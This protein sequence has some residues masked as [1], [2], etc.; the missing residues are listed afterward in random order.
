MPSPLTFLLCAA[1][2][3][4]LGAAPVARALDPAT[5][6][7]DYHHT[8]WTS[9]DGAPAEITSMAQ[10]QDGWLWL[11]TPTGV[12]RFDGV[13]FEPYQ[14]PAGSRLLH[15]RISE[16][17]AMPNGD[18]W[19]GYVGRGLSLRHA[20][21][22]LEHVA[23]ADSKVRDVFTLTRDR[24]GSIWAA[25][26]LGTRRYDAQRRWQAIGREAG[27]PAASLTTLADQHGRLY[28][29]ADDGTYVLDRASAKFERISTDYTVSLVESPD[30]QLWGGG[31]GV[32]RKLPTPSP[33]I[34]RPDWLNQ[35]EGH[36]AGI[37]DRD[38]NLWT[39]RCPRGLCLVRQPQRLG[40]RI[41]PARDAS[42]KFDQ[43]WQLSNLS[44]NLLL[45]DRLGNI[46]LSTQAG[47]E[48]FRNAAVLAAPV[49]GA[50][51]FYRLAR[52]AGDTVWVTDVR[53]AQVWR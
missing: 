30:G 1:G 18:L 38:G 17:V 26:T 43:P 14:P 41:Q 42:E 44:T 36:A 6:L 12:Y 19:I 34:A 5:A 51:G 13:R 33:T 25:S 21:G 53:A 47:L 37:F 2:V 52:G 11:G 39:L 15:N 10:T 32:L 40:G 50:D 49:P 4:S 24:D 3:V 28:L 7:Q 20:D 31:N 23:D 29:G 48:R 22:R 16:L 45:E 46:W 35:A 8:I 9:R 27:V